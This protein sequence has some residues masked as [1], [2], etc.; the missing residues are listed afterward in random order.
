[1]LRRSAH[2]FSIAS[3]FSYAGV[4][5]VDLD[6]AADEDSAGFVA[7]LLPTVLMLGR[8]PTIFC[9]VKLQIVSAGGLRLLDDLIKRGNLAFGVS[10]NL[11]AACAVRFLLLGAGNGY[12]SLMGLRLEVGAK[13]QAH[14]PSGGVAIG[15]VAM[16]GPAV[17][18]YTYG[19]LGRNS[20][21]LRPLI[22]LV[23][24]L[25]A[26]VFTLIWLPE[27]GHRQ[28]PNRSLQFCPHLSRI[29]RPIP[30]RRS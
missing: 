3:I 17:G 26:A 28:A 5:A 30:M 29:P 24:G 16:G 10:A 13:R 12:A 20:Q 23:L 14:R 11:A 22:G 7:G 25:L 9:G 21:R 27:T 18:G 19:R 4:L 2:F 15:I 8:L 6:W 1:M